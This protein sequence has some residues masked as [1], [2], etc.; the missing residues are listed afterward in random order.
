MPV[1]FSYSDIYLRR[2]SA[3]FLGVKDR[4]NPVLA[5]KEFSESLKELWVECSKSTIS[6]KETSVTWE[7]V[8][9]RGS[10][11][12]GAKEKVFVLRKMPAKVPDIDG[13]GLHP[14]IVRRLVEDVRTGL[15]IIAG[16]FASGKTTTASALVKRRLER[17]GG[18]A[19]TIEDPPEMPLEGE[20][21]LNGLCF[22]TTV[23]ETESFS[24]LTKMAARW[25]P[26]IIFLGEVRDH[27]AA[28]EAIKAA[29]SGSLVIC[30]VHGNSVS[31][32]IQ[33]LYTYACADGANNGDVASLL[34]E[35]LSAVIHQSFNNKR[36][37]SEFLF[38][39]GS[40]GVK[41]HIQ[42]KLFHQ[43]DSEVMLQKNKL[44]SGA[45]R[46]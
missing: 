34:S 39:E 8:T 35:G 15:I 7:G 22:Q 42:S 24:D 12:N 26:S 13:L 40:N 44:I 27:D 45:T 14:E 9:F 31:S 21:G 5:P 38:V 32:G 29:L 1:G 41:G 19:V 6:E 3:H 43:L 37:K 17:D 36:L 18:V 23:T 33:R 2:D 46:R 10:P 20:H 4:V 16:A 28:K 11:L 30:T 25:V